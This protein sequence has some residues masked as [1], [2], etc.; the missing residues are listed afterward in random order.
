MTSMPEMVA[1]FNGLG[2]AAPLLVGW[3]ALTPDSAVFTLVTIVLSILIG[4]VTLHGFVDRL[5]QAV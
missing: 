2:G 1:L 3:S 5:G 4:G